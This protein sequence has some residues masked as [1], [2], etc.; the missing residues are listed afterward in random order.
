MARRGFS[1]IVLALLFTNA[2][3]AKGQVLNDVNRVDSQSHFKVDYLFSNEID[4]KQ[5]SVD[6]INNTVQLNVKNAEIDQDKRFDKI[7][8]PM[9]KNLYSFKLSR[10]TLAL[11]INYESDYPADEFKDRVKFEVDGKRLRVSVADGRAIRLGTLDN[12]LEKPSNLND[13]QIEDKYKYLQLK[14]SDEELTERAETPKASPPNVISAESFER[15]LADK[16]K[17][18][19]SDSIAEDI[20]TEYKPGKKQ[21]GPIRVKKVRGLSS[22]D[23]KVLIEE[24]VSLE[25]KAKKN[26]DLKESEIPVFTKDNPVKEIK[27]E[28]PVGGLMTGVFVVLG[29]VGVSVLALRRYASKKLKEAKHQTIKVLTQHHLGPKKSLAIIRVAGESILIGVTDQNINLIKP[30]SLLDDELNSMENKDFGQSLT[31]ASANEEIGLGL[32]F[33]EDEEEEFSVR[34]LK[35]MVKSRLTGMKEL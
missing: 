3:W 34:G 9:V 8:D 7:K 22:S 33:Q 29:I 23:E 1:L 4:P 14:L 31:D 32:D 15:K 2:L 27:N 30:L 12:I 35:D 5:V 26:K 6:F 13:Q 17:Y 10:D 20:P 24:E 18:D 21:E 16:L 11:R 19:Q 25:D 28:S